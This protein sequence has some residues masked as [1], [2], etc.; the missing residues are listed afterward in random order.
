MLGAGL[1]ATADWGRWGP[2]GRLWGTQSPWAARLLAN[3][4]GCDPLRSLKTREVSGEADSMAGAAPAGGREMGRRGDPTGRG[5]EGRG[6]P[7]GASQHHGLPLTMGVSF[8]LKDTEA[9]PPT[10]C[11]ALWR[12]W[13]ALQL[14]LLLSPPGG[15]VGSWKTSVTLAVQKGPAKPHQAFGRA[16]PLGIALVPR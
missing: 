10:P 6:G 7:A 5:G 3:S 9:P 15:L 16:V 13:R 14:S 4:G 11:Q 8:C 1:L 12:G 2:A